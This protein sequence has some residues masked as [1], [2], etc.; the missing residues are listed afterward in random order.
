MQVELNFAAVVETLL[1]PGVHEYLGSGGSHV[2][3]EVNRTIAGHCTVISGHPLS[4]LGITM[5]LT[6][7]PPRPLVVDQTL[8]SRRGTVSNDVIFVAIT[9]GSS[10]R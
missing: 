1:S 9:I 10:D 7:S 8:A 4:S 3:R 6:L 5:F 2:G